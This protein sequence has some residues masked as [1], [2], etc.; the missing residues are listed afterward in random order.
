MTFPI[1]ILRTL[2]HFQEKKVDNSTLSTVQV[3]RQQKNENFSLWNSQVFSFAHFFYLIPRL[4]IYFYFLILITGS[5]SNLTLVLQHNEL[6]NV[7]YV[8]LRGALVEVSVI[9]ILSLFKSYCWFWFWSCHLTLR[10][11]NQESFSPQHPA[12]LHSGIK[13]NN[14]FYPITLLSYSPG[15]KPRIISTPTHCYLTL[16]DRNQESFLPQHTV[17]LHPRTKTKNACH[18]N[19]LL[20]NTL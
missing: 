8:V 1:Y 17:T 15:P 14:H 13:T 2:C 10:D 11:R 16:C 19:T 3:S 9:Q 12:I 20:S 6:K 5:D 4:I 18:P 7:N